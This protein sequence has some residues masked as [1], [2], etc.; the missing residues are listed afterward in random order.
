MLS[1]R[2]GARQERNARECARRSRSREIKEE[3]KEKQS[4]DKEGSLGERGPRTVKGEEGKQKTRRL[5]HFPPFA[6]CE[7]SRLLAKG[8]R[9]RASSSF[10]SLQ[11]RHAHDPKAPRQLVN[12]TA[13]ALLELAKEKVFFDVFMPSL[14][15]LSLSLFPSV[16]PL[17]CP[18]MLFHKTIIFEIRLF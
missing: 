10:L 1:R 6:V 15:S 7:G 14:S 17:P 9:S 18:L 4:K 11:V 3:Q 13:L 16:P 2:E 12:K 5:A 8:A